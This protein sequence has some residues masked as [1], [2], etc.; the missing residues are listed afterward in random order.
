VRSNPDDL[1][2]LID[3]AAFL[4]RHVRPSPKSKLAIVALHG[5]G[6]D[7][8]TVIPL[9]RAIAPDAAIIAPRGRIDQNG[10]RRWFR[11]LTPTS[12]DQDDI[13]HEASA[14]ADFLDGLRRDG[15][16]GAVENTLVIGY[17]N[18]GNLASSVML[19][20][21]GR[22]R[23]LVLL[24]CMPVLHRAPMTDLSGSKALVVAGRQDQTYGPYARNLAGLLRRRGASVAGKS[25]DAGHLFGERDVVLIRSW[26]T[27]R[28]PTPAG[29]RSARRPV[30]G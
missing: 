10:E 30:H 28:P 18:G 24:R 9:A 7:E 11:K 25:V 16:I 8:T 21:P 4:Y 6:T 29:S 22:I 2:E 13:R 20:H 23:R 12:F 26:L 17:S 15:R 19:L 14:F 3:D 1:G 5:S 27:P